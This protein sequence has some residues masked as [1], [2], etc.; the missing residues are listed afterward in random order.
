[1]TGYRRWRV[2][3]GC[4]FFTVNLARRKNNSLLVQ[5]INL[6][7]KAFRKVKQAHP[8]HLDAVV[9]L[10]EHLHCVL[11]LPDGDDD[12]SM[13][14]RQIKSAFSEKLPPI[15]YRSHS[16]RHKNERGIWQRRFWE[17]VI[18]NEEDYAAHVDYVH[19]NPVKHG[20]VERVIDWPYSSFHR[21]VTCGLYPMDWSD[22][23]RIKDLDL[24]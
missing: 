20:H 12:Y 17:H 16:R 6:L 3:G 18:R 24:D 22:T 15:E 9:V 13:R 7:R 1:M 10:P 4:Y 14:W 8:F 2:P 19:Y 23:T 11:T 21:Y 5:H